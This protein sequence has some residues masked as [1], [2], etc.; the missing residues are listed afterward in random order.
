MSAPFKVRIKSEY[1]TVWI[2]DKA[3]LRDAQIAYCRARDFSELGA[4]GFSCGTVMN[5]KNNIV[6]RI[7]YNGR[8]WPAG[9]WQPG[10]SPLAEAP[11]V[12]ECRA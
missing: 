10:M 1:G 8:L 5:A 3:T 7:S 9:P 11:S 12:A 2:R 6:A 4:S